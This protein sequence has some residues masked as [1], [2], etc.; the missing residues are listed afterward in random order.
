M[1]KVNTNNNLV[2]IDYKKYQKDVD[3]VHKIIHEKKGP[4][5]DYLGWLEWPINYDKEEVKRILE[6]ASY[7]RENFDILVVCGIG[8]SYLGARAAIEAI[9]GL[10]SDDKLEIVYL[11]QTLSPTYTNQVLNYLRGKK[12]AINVISKSGTTTETSIA[13]RLVKEML[14]HEIGKEAAA[15]AIFATTDKEKG[16]LKTLA[17]SNGYETFVLPSDIGG[18]YSV[19]TAVGLFPLACAGINIKEMLAG[20]KKAKKQLS[21]KKIE[22]NPAYLYAVNRDYLYRHGKSVELFVLYE[23]QFTQIGEWLKQLFGESEGKEHKGLFP[24]SV[25]NSTDLHSLGQ[26]IQEGTPLL[27]ETIIYV[28]EPT[29]DVLIPHDVDNLDELNYLA[30]KPLSF[31]NEKAY[32]GTLDAHVKEGNVP[33]LVISIERMDAYHLGYLFYFFMKVCAM[34][35]YL[36]DVN[37]F[38]QPGVEVYKQNMFKLLGK[39][40]V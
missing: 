18:R 38:N 23:P 10:Y 36:L 9:R 1:I 29:E 27:F 30:T 32:L 5:N 6:A 15:K 28:E 3:R 21:E 33:N 19:L 34:S 31:V 8:G 16:A 22:K 37:P 17:S 39:P 2:E 7:V 26:F 25:T 11:G 12:Y 4:G 35:A 40:R 13:F 14:E 24:A 20:A